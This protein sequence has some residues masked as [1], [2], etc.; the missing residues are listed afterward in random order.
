MPMT[1]TQLTQE[2]TASLCRGFA[3]LLHAGIGIQESTRLLRREDA[4]PADRVLTA[5]EQELD[6]GTPL[7]TAM[8]QT[9]AFPAYV[10]ALT[11]VGEESG[12][13]EEALTSLA[14]YYE[15]R[16]RTT[17][18][19]KNALAYPML[20]FLAMLVVIGVLLIK[21]LPVFDRVYRNLGSR[22]TGLA[23]GM[24]QLGQLLRAALPVL[25][26]ILAFLAVLVLAVALLPALREAALS[27]FQ[28]HFGDRGVLRSFN[29]AKFVRA[30]AMGLESGLPLED[31]LELAEGLLTPSP[32]AA[33]RVAP[34]RTQ[35]DAGASL[36]DALQNAGILSPAAGRLLAAGVLSGS[37]ETV[38][39]Q[40]AREL[41]DTAEDALT[42]MISQIEPAMVL[43]ASVLVGVILLSTMLPL[44]NIL[45]SIG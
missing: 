2:Q 41:M 12:R 4:G 18:L 13:L 8:E 36:A 35:T 29:N 33:A 25:L 44:M 27:F 39:N 17:R 37:T 10:S 7:S 16:Q 11:R 19:L 23:G 30:L 20:V 32:A 34:C 5:L 43:I 15:E 6:Q 38:L 22:L 28:K 1:R 9:G 21:V 14:E 42:R 40:Q 45:T 24:L 3:L 31:S 26:V